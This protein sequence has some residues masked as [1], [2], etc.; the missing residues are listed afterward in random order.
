MPRTILTK[1]KR[2]DLSFEV[3]IEELCSYLLRREAVMAV[4]EMHRRRKGK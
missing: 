1:S 3:S 2:G 4:E